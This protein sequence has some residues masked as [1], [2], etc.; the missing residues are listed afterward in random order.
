M[1]ANL[2]KYFECL[3]Y[4]FIEGENDT[5]IRI[6]EDKCHFDF[7]LD[8][9]YYDSSL[10]SERDRLFTYFDQND[11]ICILFPNMILGL[12]MAK[13]GLH[14]IINTQEKILLQDLLIKNMKNNNIEEKN[15][16][17]LNVDTFHFFKK[18]FSSTNTKS[19]PKHIYIGLFLRDLS[20]LRNSKF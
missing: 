13:L 1:D 5:L 8:K 17:I 2:Q 18:I 15:L 6:E 3:K 14:V 7:Y 12:R 10:Q 4:E 11:I 20:F 9:Y 19:S 16:E